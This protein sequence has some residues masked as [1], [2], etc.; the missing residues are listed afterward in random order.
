MEELISYS[1]GDADLNNPC[2]RCGEEVGYINDVSAHQH[3]L[4]AE[5]TYWYKAKG[6]KL[7]SYQR[8]TSSFRTQP[9]E[10]NPFKPVHQKIPALGT[11]DGVKR[12]IFGLR[13]RSQLASVQRKR[14]ANICN[15]ICKLGQVRRD[16]CK[17]CQCDLPDSQ[18]GQKANLV[19]NCKLLS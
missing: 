3:S 13:R 11:G 17:T 2:R 19:S 18:A 15:A 16:R 12:N 4:A 10:E 6:G 8:S 9:R 7:F 14:K 1:N 5:C